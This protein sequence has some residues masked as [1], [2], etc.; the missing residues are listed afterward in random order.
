MTETAGRNV[1]L[2]AGGILAVSMIAMLVLAERAASSAQPVSVPSALRW[3]LVALPALAAVLGLAGAWAL[4]GR[5]ASWWVAAGSVLVLGGWAS[6]LVFNEPTS[7]NVF[8]FLALLLGALAVL[9]GCVLAVT[10]TG[11]RHA[12]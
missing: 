1:A 4:R 7:I 10:G 11:R 2:T 8:G 3:L 12:R 6:F 5:A 9:V